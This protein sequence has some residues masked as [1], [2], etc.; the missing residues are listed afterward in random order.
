MSS[1]HLW[2]FIRIGLVSLILLAAVAGLVLGD[3]W[4]WVAAEWAPPTFGELYTAD[5]SDASVGLAL[6]GAALVKAAFLWL[7]L[8]TPEWGPLDRGER[9]LRRLLYL[10]VAHALVLWYSVAL[11]PDAVDA[12]FTLVLWAAVDVLYLLVIR[13][14]SRLLRGAA[15]AVRGRT[16][17]DSRRTARRARPPGARTGRRHPAGPDLRWSSGDLRHRPRAVA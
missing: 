2:R 7:I 15:G 4:L 12:A 1:E 3:T 6:F 17:R 5:G 16:G 8:R 11:L 10:A 14:R 9:A 13:W